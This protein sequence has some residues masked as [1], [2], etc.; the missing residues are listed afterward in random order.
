MAITALAPTRLASATSRSYAS[1]RVRSASDW[2]T[3]GVMLFDKKIFRT[4]DGGRTWNPVFTCQARVDVDGLPRTVD[5]DL[6]RM[7]IAGERVAYA[8]GGSYQAEVGIVAKTV[9]AGATWQVLTAAEKVS[10]SNDKSDVRFLDENTGYARFGDWVNGQLFRTTDGG[11][12]WTGVAGSVGW[13]MRFADPEI[14]W[15]LNQGKLSFTTDGGK[16]WSSRAITFPATPAAFSFPRRDTAYVVGAHGMIFRYRVLP[17]AVPAPAKSLDAPAMPS[18]ANG[19]IGE[20]AKLESGLAQVE[21]GIE[22]ASGD[23]GAANWSGSPTA[24]RIAQLQTTADSLATGV[25]ELGSRSRN[26]NTVMLGLRLLSELTKQGNSLRQSFALLR[27]ARDP[28]SAAAALAEVSS[29]LKAMKT[30][31]A[32]FSPT[33]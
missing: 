6:W 17:A 29:G 14:G 18:I 28:G 8:S 24:L 13:A 2:Y 31:V 22:Q 30:S 12:T 19:V 5:C 16:R 9:D 27:Q 32:A 15:C 26:L 10:A 7:S 20:I 3:V 25:P 4:L 23:T 33:R 11:S 1:A 21:T